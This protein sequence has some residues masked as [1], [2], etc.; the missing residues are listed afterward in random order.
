[1]EEIELVFEED[2]L[3]RLAE[4]AVERGTGARGLRSILEK[5][6]LDIMYEVPS[7][8]DVKKCIIT[9]DTIDTG[10]PK[11]ELK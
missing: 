10:E 8:D 11:L 5:S 1:M 3:K 7:R 6:M 9:K 2:A 4:K